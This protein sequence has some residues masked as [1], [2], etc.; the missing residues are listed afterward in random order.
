MVISGSSSL[1][2]EMR[3]WRERCEEAGFQILDWPAPMKE[4]D[5]DDV[6]PEMHK[7]FYEAIGKA[8]ILFVPNETKEGREAYIGAGV[9]AE[10]SFAM[11]LNFVREE[12]MEIIILNRPKEGSNFH[13]DIIRWEK[14]GWL[15][16]GPPEV[17][18]IPYR[19]IIDG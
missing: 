13:E 19:D 7:S 18:N 15:R 6:F 10:I 5:F 3:G 14:Y 17:M 16:I 1:K 4:G 2:E 11:G 9:F 12:K 8:D